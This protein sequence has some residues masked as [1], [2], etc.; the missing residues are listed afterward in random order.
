[1]PRDVW[2]FVLIV[3]VIAPFRL[4]QTAHVRWMLVDGGYYTE[5]ARH[6]RDGLGLTTHVSLYH[7]GYENFP[8]PTPIYPLWPWILG[9][10]A[11]VGDLYQL[12]HWL[13]LALSFVALLAAFLFG[14]ALAPGDLF[15]RLPGFHAGHLAALMLGLQREFVVYTSLPYTEGIAWSLLFL[16]AWR[17]ARERGAL[18]MAG[19][20]EA[21]VWMGLL[22][23]ARAQLMV[24]PM[25]LAVA[26]TLRFAL[27]PDRPRVA[28]HGAVALGVFGLF[29]GA[30]WAHLRAIVPG[31][32]LAALLRFDQNR[33]NDL[34]APLDVIVATDGPLAF[35]AD[36][37]RGVAVAWGLVP[38]IGYADAFHTLHW[39]L[40]VALPFAGLA[41]A[42]ALR[43]DGR[44]ALLARLAAPSAFPWIFLGV[45]AAG[46]LLSVQLAHKQYNGEWYFARR[47]GLVALFAFFLSLW[48]LLARAGR[49]GRALGGLVLVSSLWMGVATLWDQAKD[50]RS[51]TR[52]R[53]RH[54]ALVAWLRDRA[55]E[56]G[57]VVAMDGHLTQ[58]VAWRTRDVGYHWFHEE[59]SYADLLTLTD[60]LG[61]RYV[62]LRPGSL[63][64]KWRFEKQAG[65]A[66]KR[67]FR[68]LSTRPD[69]HVILERRRDGPSGLGPTPRETGNAPHLPT[70]SDRSRAVGGH[71]RADEE[72]P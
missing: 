66:L 13:P 45:L 64:G 29:L 25:A 67:D 6:V 28:A 53:D 42:R 19:A 43:R 21:G 27:G 4:V 69:K 32:G 2:L 18:R 71:G 3:A 52:G 44:A 15:R 63:K 54:G 22:Y 57:V 51:E 16:F 72:A 47:Q 60:R 55:D 23:L 59:T 36:R 34:L 1:M 17:L 35:L 33:A 24:V 58:R 7:M 41:L 65:D 49:F 68:R 48:W 8:H 9:M 14:R 11:R 20:V 46:A 40:P 38:G 26:Y 5:V 50:R 61:A 31:A 39:A 37:A 12:A 30:W 62:V 10:S 56:G 70:E